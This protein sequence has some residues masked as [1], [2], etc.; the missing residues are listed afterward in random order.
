MR[1]RVPALALIA[2]LGCRR[3]AGPLVFVSNERG[4]TIT[5]IDTR[6]D[7]V[8]RTIS[9]GS[10]P[11]GIQWRG[12]KLYAALTDVGTRRPN[13]RA[14]IAEIDV[15]QGYRIR[16]LPSG[17]DPETL[18]VSPDGTRIFVSNEDANEASIVDVVSGKILRSLPVGVEP[19]GVTLSPDG[20]W[21]WVT[22]ESSGTVTVIDTARGEVAAT[23]P[24]EGRPRSAA[25]SPD[26]SRGYVS[27]ELGGS[28]CVVDVRTNSVT[29]C[30]RLAPG[31]RP[32]GIV[33]S[34][35]GR[36]VYAAT[37]RGNTVVVLDAAGKL[38]GRI[39]VGQRPWG[40]GLTR[41]GKKLYVANG[42]SNDVSVIDTQTRKI[43]RTV[44]GGDG[45][46]GVAV[47]N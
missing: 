39:P 25:F 15:R 20:R 23:I 8:V 44:P 41:D 43:L 36:E 10:R 11:R 40:I 46:W 37:G 35:A 14:A 5:V 28:V 2:A 18:A 7:E 45:P 4:G 34:P 30:T 1:A 6:T 19:E 12:G 9:V 29:G 31:E 16:W 42:P 17:A 27:C 22:A 47:G 24:V 32:V 21:C 26:G 3:Q 13:A 33:A 38:L